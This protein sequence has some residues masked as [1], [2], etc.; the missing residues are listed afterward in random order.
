MSAL[1]A[2]V[3]TLAQA[4]AERAR[5]TPDTVAERHKRLG[6]W[7]EF[8]FARVQDEVRAL[9]LGLQQLGVTRG[10]VVLVIG[11]NEPQHFWTEY[12]AHALGAAVVSLYP[13]QNADEMAYLAQD[14]GAVVIVA[15]D[16]E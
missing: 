3:Q 1:P 8:T 16:Q 13:D 6:I 10:S 12:A 2:T 14:S 4:L 11:E 5:A 15:R 7:Q 9:A